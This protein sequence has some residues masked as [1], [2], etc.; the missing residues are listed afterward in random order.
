MS[1]KEN[2]MNRL[3]YIYN[4]KTRKYESVLNFSNDDFQV[5]VK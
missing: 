3:V 1:G 2:L 4:A 5:K